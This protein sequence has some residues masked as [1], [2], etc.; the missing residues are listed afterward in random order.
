MVRGAVRHLCG[1]VLGATLGGCLQHQDTAMRGNADYVSISYTGDA[2]ET[3]R[4]A[5]QHCA[6]YERA[7]VLRSATDNVAVYA[8]VRANASP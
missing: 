8:C 2:S 1:V 7:P 4:L 6:Q 3:L 5:R